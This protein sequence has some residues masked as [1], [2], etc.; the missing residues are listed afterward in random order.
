MPPSRAPS[1]KIDG[2]GL[3]PNQRAEPTVDAIVD[4]ILDHANRTNGWLGPY[5]NE[6]GDTNGHGLWDPLNTV[7]AL[8]RS[9]LAIEH[10]GGAAHR[11][12]AE[13]LFAPRASLLGS[14][15]A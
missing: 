15:Q 14:Q 10:G 12:Q 13:A 7:R 4:Y 8:L 2:G 11:K 5:A 9:Y 6:P 3:G 1:R